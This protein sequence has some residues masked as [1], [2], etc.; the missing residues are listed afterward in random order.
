MYFDFLWNRKKNKIK[1]VILIKT[2]GGRR[3]RNEIYL[4]SIQFYNSHG[5]NASL[6]NED[7]KWKTLRKPGL[8]I[9]ALLNTGGFTDPKIIH[10]VDSPF[11]KEV[12]KH[13][14]DYPNDLKT[15]PNPLTFRS[16]VVYQI[17]FCNN[18]ITQ[19][20]IRNGKKKISR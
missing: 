9:D 7:K 15:P 19:Q 5:S 13:E 20:R 12:F 8:D 10:K 4:Y 6:Q 14:N 2:I 17:L 11:W 3:N 16:E 18:I 1:R